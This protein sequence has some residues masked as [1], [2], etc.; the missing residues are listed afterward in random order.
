MSNIYQRTVQLGPREGRYVYITFDYLQIQDV[1]DRTLKGRVRK[2]G[3]AGRFH[4]ETDQ[5]NGVQMEA[6]DRL[7][8]DESQTYIRFVSGS[9][10]NLIITFLSGVGMLTIEVKKK[11]DLINTNIINLPTAEADTINNNINVA[12]P[13]N[14][15]VTVNNTVN[16]PA[17]IANITVESP[18]VDVDIA[19]TKVDVAAPDVTVQSPMVTVESPEVTVESPTVNVTTPEV[20]V[21]VQPATPEVKVAPR[22]MLEQQQGTNI[23]HRDLMDN[24]LAVANP[25]ANPLYPSINAGGGARTRLLFG[26][27]VKLYHYNFVSNFGSISRPAANELFTVEREYR[28]SLGIDSAEL[29]K[30]KSM[31]FLFTPGVLENDP[32]QLYDMQTLNADRCFCAMTLKVYSNLGLVGGG[33]SI[34]LNISN[35]GRKVSNENVMM[36]QALYSIR[37]GRHYDELMSVRSDRNVLTSKV[38][39]FGEVNLSGLNLFQYDS[40]RISA[41]ITFHY[42]GIFDFKV[43]GA[44]QRLGGNSSANL[45]RGVSLFHRFDSNYVAIYRG[46]NESAPVSLDEL[47]GAFLSQKIRGVYEQFFRD[48]FRFNM[49][50]IKS[51]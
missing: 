43:S 25:V 24:I 38:N 46:R 31:F 2:S 23:V 44:W 45:V 10:G 47:P 40:P 20:N 16:I 50:Y 13:E 11:S 7:Q 34:L 39:I 18:D 12:A 26:R 14:P 3:D 51:D 30:I 35:G 15:D 36:D 4:I 17:D 1:Q 28:F 8:W 29:K 27:N 42:V 37:G 33:D 48:I 49:I 32:T 5:S 6:G 21:T 9:S 41:S 22:I 19:A